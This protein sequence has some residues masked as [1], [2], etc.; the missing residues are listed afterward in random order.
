MVTIFIRHYLF[1]SVGAAVRFFI[2][3]LKSLQSGKRTPKFKQ[4]YDYRKNPEN[5]LLDAIIGFLILGLSL[6]I[7]LI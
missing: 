3:K 2:E 1:C 6:T 4:I 5:E 7:I